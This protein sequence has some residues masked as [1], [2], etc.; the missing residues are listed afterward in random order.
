M[1]IQK[2]EIAQTTRE[3]FDRSHDFATCGVQK[4]QLVFTL[5]LVLDRTIEYSFLL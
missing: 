1:A 5:V 3:Y 2:P 4:A